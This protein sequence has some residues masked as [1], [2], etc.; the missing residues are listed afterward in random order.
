MR[1]RTPRLQLAV[2]TH[3][4]HM[5]LPRLVEL[6]ELQ[7][8][9]LVELHPLESARRERRDVARLGSTVPEGVPPGVPRVAAGPSIH[10]ANQHVL[11]H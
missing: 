5:L 4:R 1:P 3:A 10:L 11:P 8:R 2:I 6:A 9:E 7:R